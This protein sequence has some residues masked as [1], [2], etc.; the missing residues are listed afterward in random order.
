MAD[1]FSILDYIGATIGLRASEDSNSKKASVIVSEMATVGTS[2][3]RPNDTTA[4]AVDDAIA[5][6]TS[7]ASVLTFAG[8]ARNTGMGGTIVGAALLIAN[9]ATVAAEFHLMLYDTSPTAQNDN[10]AFA[11]GANDLG[12]L[13]GTLMF[14]PALM[15][16]QG[17]GSYPFRVYQAVN[18]PLTYRCAA[19]GLY[20]LLKTRTA[21][22]PAA[23]T[24][25]RIRM[26][27]IKES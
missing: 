24:L 20:G 11:H 8:M 23:Q 17:G 9:K 2:F 4:Y 5:N 15:T 10:A 13:V 1:N 19:T 21:Y 3:T 25:Y 7:G 16:D 26:D 22:T 6:A 27:V 14:T 18:L 12:Y